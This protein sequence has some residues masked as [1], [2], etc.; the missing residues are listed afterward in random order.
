MD[1]KFSRIVEL[2]FLYPPSKFQ[3]S[4]PLSLI[5]MHLQMLKI[6]CVNYACFPKSGHICAF[7]YTT[8]KAYKATS[9]K[10]YITQLV[11]TEG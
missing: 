5:F 2:L 7:P 9:R 4:T 6:G 1:V 8:R 10:T 11:S 3:P